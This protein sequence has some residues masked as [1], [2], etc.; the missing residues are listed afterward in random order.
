[1]RQAR[2]PVCQQ[3][4]VVSDGTDTQAPFCSRR[5]RDA[6]LHRWFAEGYAV[7]VATERVAQ[8]AL[9]DAP[10]GGAWDG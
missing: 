10:D 7:P 4:F 9:P 5:C 1:M 2:C 3:S 8:D 6:D